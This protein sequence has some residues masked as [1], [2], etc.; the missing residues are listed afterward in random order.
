MIGDTSLFARQDE[1]EAAW[2]VV[3]Q[4][5]G[6]N[7]TPIEYVAGSWGPPQ[8]DELIC[9][10]CNWHNPGADAH[11]WTRSCVSELSQFAP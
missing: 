9:G 7:S 3:D 8:A 1:V 5:V 6:L 11:N 2:A 4:V 10:P